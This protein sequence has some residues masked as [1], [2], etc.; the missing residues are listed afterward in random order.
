MAKGKQACINFLEKN[1]FIKTDVE[2]ESYANDHC[3]VVFED[4]VSM[5]MAFN[6]GTQFFATPNIYF[7]IGWLTYYGHIDKNYKI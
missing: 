6:D 4:N 3:N 2:I 5:I 1:G 7:L